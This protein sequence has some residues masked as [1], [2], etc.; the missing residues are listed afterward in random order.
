MWYCAGFEAASNLRTGTSEPMKK[1][2]QLTFTGAVQASAEEHGAYFDKELQAWFV[3]GEV[4]GPLISFTVK[5]VRRRDYVAEA[6]P[7]QC[8]CGTQMIVRKNRSTGEPFW[9]CTSHRCP[10]VRQFDDVAPKIN[11]AG[12][13]TV[14]NAEGSAQFESK[15]RVAALIART[16][17]LFR[18]EGV[19]TAW[20]KAPKV[21]LGGATPL[22]AMK[23]LV[24]CG[25][26][27][28]LLEER[29]N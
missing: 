9:A 10:G 13:A 19:A 3:D 29:F 26:V 25:A 28:R 11:R 6:A 2:T 23:T 18:N 4:P 12:R 8:G 1:R 24:G 16:I 17:E 7:P 20:L 15:D 14:S 5:E 22:D 27:E 21:G